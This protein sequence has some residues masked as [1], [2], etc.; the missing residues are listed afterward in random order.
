MATSAYDWSS[1]PVMS[2][3]PS[4]EEVAAKEQEMNRARAGLANVVAMPVTAAVSPYS[5]MLP[6][7]DTS[8]PSMGGLMGGLLPLV[9]PELGPV[10]A[11][12]QFATKAPA[13]VRPFI[14]SLAGSTAGTVAGTLGEQ[15]LLGQD[16]FSTETGAK[17]LGN[18]L[19][20]AAL[21]TAGNLAFSIGGKAYQVTKDALSKAG[22]KTGGLMN[23]FSPEEQARQAAQEWF[24][25]RGATLTKGQL[26]GDVGTQML[27]GAL[28]YSSGAEAFAKQQANVK[29]AIEQGANDVLNTLDTSDAFKMALMQGDPTKVAVGD[30]FQS[31]IKAAETAMKDK[32]RPVYE[33]LEQEGNGMFVNMRPLKDNAKAELDKLAKSKFAGAGSERRRAL[34]EILSQ[35]DSVPLSVAHNLR[36][37]LLA[38][39]RE[40]QKEGVPTTALQREYNLQADGI[41][42]QMD[43]VMVTT[44][45]NQEDKDLARKL[46]FLGG[47]DSPAGLREGQKLNY[48]QTVDQLIAGLGRTKATTSNNALLRDYFNAQKGYGD[49]MQGFYSGTVASALKSE[50]SA[51]GEYLFN[52][53]RP[54]R[55]R[56]TFGAIVQAQKYLPKEQSKGLSEE[57][58]YGYL[59]KA[60]DS[61]EAIAQLG[62]NIGLSNK[63]NEFKEAFDFLFNKPEQRKTIEDLARAA[64]FGTE[65]FAGSSALRTKGITTAFGVAETA[66]L[67][68]LAY[69]SLPPEITDKLDVTNSAISAGVLYLTPKMISRSLTSKQNMDTLAMITKAQSNPKFAGAASAKIA[70]MLNKSGILTNEYLKTTD[71]FF[72]GSQ[73]PTEVPTSAPS[74]TYDWTSVPVAPQQ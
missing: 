40:A 64:Q 12:T 24:S 66:A 60:F 32:Y 10:R 37:D 68:T 31:A 44:F 1:V 18:V 46:G 62:K 73:Q 30:R 39:A 13:A 58:M 55:M 51:I 19:E 53:D 45:G 59:K 56:E 43:D 17:M 65:S 57:L 7:S 29:K 23:A 27:E 41:R 4:R 8:L 25:K 22:V 74:G 50:P 28:K 61:P 63:K 20:N 35:D 69:L 3:G 11:I 49:A 54:E 14:P 9:A 21:D 16:I 70:D 6:S 42:R 52:L 33:R 71:E 36:S 26:T 2:Q 38:G 5:L 34:E 15:A 48:A 72:H 67:G 47:V